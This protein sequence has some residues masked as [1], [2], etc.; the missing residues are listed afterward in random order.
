MR[1]QEE[2]RKFKEEIK[3]TFVDKGDVKEHILNMDIVDING[4]FIPGRSIP[5][6]LGGH[7]FQMMLVLSGLMS[8]FKKHPD[9][10]MLKDLIMD[11]KKLIELLISY[12]KDMKQDHIIIYLHP[13]AIKEL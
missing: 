7:T 5:G 12:L 4:Q 6:T 11:K 3:A 10:K 1:K 8:T 13:E 9:F 2:L